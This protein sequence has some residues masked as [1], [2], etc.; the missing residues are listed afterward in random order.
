MYNE[1]FEKMNKLGKT[2]Y[3][4]M[5]ELYEINM[6]IAGQLSEQQMAFVNLY[7]ECTTSQFE[8]L[9]KSKDYKDIISS[10]TALINETSEKVQ[11]IARN[12]VDIMNETKD[13]VSA[14]VESGVKDA[15]SI[16]PFPKT[17]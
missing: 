16:V 14:W 12:T 6:K 1:M 7:M 17:A 15:S 3:D 13:D 10:Q 9:G 11:G 4:A 8:M 5:K 2:G